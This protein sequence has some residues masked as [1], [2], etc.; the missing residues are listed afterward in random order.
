MRGLHLVPDAGCGVPANHA[1]VQHGNAGA[2]DHGVELV[3]RH[4]LGQ[5]APQGEN[6]AAM[7]VVG[8]HATAAEFDHAFTQAAQPGEVKLGVAVGA[9]HA[10]GLHGRQHA[11]GAYDLPGG[12]VA[13]QQVFAV[14]VKQVNVVAR[15][16]RVQARAHFSGKHLVT[17][18]LRGAHFILV[19]RP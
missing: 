14:I 19:A 2:T 18:P 7:A 11:V 6:H 10:L 15:Q 8:V 16:R 9:A 1:L 5:G 4:E 17:Q 12:A 3:A 13:H